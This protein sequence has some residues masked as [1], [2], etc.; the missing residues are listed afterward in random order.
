MADATPSATQN[1]VSFQRSV[2]RCRRRDSDDTKDYGPAEDG[3]AEHGRN[4]DVASLLHK[5]QKTDA[6][7]PTTPETA[8]QGRTGAHCTGPRSQWAQRP[9]NPTRKTLP[10]PARPS[11]HAISG[12]YASEENTVEPPV[13]TVEKWPLDGAALERV[14]QNG[15]T[16]LRLVFTLSACDNLR[17]KRRA[18]ESRRQQSPAERASP[19]GRALTSEVVSTVEVYED[20]YFEVDD[21]LDSRKI[22]DRRRRRWW[23][24]YL[25]KWKGYGHE[26]N[27]WE[28]AANFNKCPEVLIRYHERNLERG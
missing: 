23:R 12:A 14:T 6:S 7:A 8:P 3:V 19:T 5:R 18:A 11:Q 2:D 9:N 22:L 17:Q 21:I 16:T 10:K 26:H 25:V 15:V 1:G 27:S 4:G 28:P 20:D 24:E 13:T